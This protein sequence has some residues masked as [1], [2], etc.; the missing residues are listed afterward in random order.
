[1]RLADPTSLVLPTSHSLVKMDD[2][3]RPLNEDDGPPPKRHASST[4]G[5]KKI[6]R[7]ADMP[8]K[9]DLEVGLDLALQLNPIADH[10]RCVSSAS[11]RMPF[12]DRCRS[13]SVKRTPSKLV[14]TT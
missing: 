2:R 9:D 11:K 5:D 3:K 6:D 12:S 8:W 1:M 14:S 10:S 4:N 13:L 7:D